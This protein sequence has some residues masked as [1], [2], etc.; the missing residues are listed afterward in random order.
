[1]R[2]SMLKDYERNICIIYVGLAISLLNDPGNQEWIGEINPIFSFVY[3]LQWTFI[4][5]LNMQRTRIVI[6]SSPR[7]KVRIY[8]I[9]KGHRWKKQF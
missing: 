4:Q 9:K 8:H 6:S 2:R 5:V 7:R 3:D 1:M